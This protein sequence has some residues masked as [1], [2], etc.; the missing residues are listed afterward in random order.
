MQGQQFQ[1]GLDA[2]AGALGAQLSAQVANAP[3]QYDP[4]ISQ[5]PLT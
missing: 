1:A 4:N 3:W 2:Q 5:F